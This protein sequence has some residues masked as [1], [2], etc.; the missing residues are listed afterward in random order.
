MVAQSSASSVLLP[1]GN[2]P[3]Q[4]DCLINDDY[5]G[6]IIKQDTNCEQRVFNHDL[7]S[8][9][10]SP[11]K[12]WDGNLSTAWV[13]GVPGPGIGQVIIVDINP[14]V[15]IKIRSG[16]AA[17][18]TLFEQNNR[19]RKVRFYLLGV[20]FPIFTQSRLGLG[21]IK[22]LAS[23]THELPDRNQWYAVQ[24]QW[25]AYRDDSEYSRYL[26]AVEILSV[27]PGTK[28]DDTGISEIAN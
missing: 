13:E 28:Y 18:Q 7:W 23:F 15:D 27:Y 20:Q 17:S 14:F 8:C 10:Y 12:A 16:I 19:P 5:E 26:L 11:A 22:T 1:S 2:P 4:A 25:D 24:P 9:T 21:G 3:D 6:L